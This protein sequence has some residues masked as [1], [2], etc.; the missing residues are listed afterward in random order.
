LPIHELIQISANAYLVASLLD[1][2]LHFSYIQP[3]QERVPIR[4]L[5]FA[6]TV[7]PGWRK[8]LDRVLSTIGDTC[9]LWIH[10]EDEWVDVKCPTIEGLYFAGDTYGR[11]TNEG[12]IEGATHSVFICADAIT[13]KDY[14]QFLPPAFR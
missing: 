5:K 2:Q 3:N 8:S 7:F 13:G 9:I 12:G 1:R 14:L 11:R 4:I 10:P 6:D